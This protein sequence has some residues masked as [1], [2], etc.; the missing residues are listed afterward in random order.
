MNQLTHGEVE[1]EKN[2]EEENPAVLSE[3][4]IVEDS[5]IQIENVTE[6]QELNEEHNVI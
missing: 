2:S 1:G 4:V 6:E 5:Q 3:T